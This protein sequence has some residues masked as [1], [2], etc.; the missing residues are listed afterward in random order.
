MT[1][2]DA[3][4]TTA[5]FKTRSRST[6]AA[7]DAAITAVLLSASREID[8]HCGDRFFGQDG[9]VSVP[10][11]RYAS[12]SPLAWGID[13]RP[14]P[15]WQPMT[16]GGCLDIPDT[17]S[18]SEVA[19][20]QDGDGVY[21]TV[22]DAAE[23]ALRPRNALAT[24]EPFTQLRTTQAATHAFPTGADAIRLSGIFGWPAVPAPVIEVCFMLAN[25][26]KSLW[27]APFGLSGGG[28]MGALDMTVSLTPILK[29]MLSP[30]R[31][32]TV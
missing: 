18:L 7:N 9:T 3:Y 10:A 22:W 12:I 31:A 17:V 16:G 15:T 20:D 28:E 30:Y 1:L 25:R 24:G 11:I 6:T 26:L 5:A 4:L 13:V 32:V 14:F 21:E 2:G 19:T 27:D 23:W 29:N 8:R